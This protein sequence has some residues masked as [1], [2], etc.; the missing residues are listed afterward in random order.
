MKTKFAILAMAAALV[1]QASGAD[2]TITIPDGQV[3]RVLN[4][5]AISR[6]YS[7][8]LV[9]PSKDDPVGIPET[10]AQFARR[11]MIAWI[12]EQVKEAEGGAAAKTARETA[13]AAAESIGVN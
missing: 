7:G 3:A 6:G 5:I 2:I 9:A 10:K 13:N 4:G 1:M 8:Y 12:I 11:M